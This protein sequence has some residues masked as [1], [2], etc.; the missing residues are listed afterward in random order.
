MADHAVKTHFKNTN[1]V[2]Y[3]FY[4]KSQKLIK[5]VICHLPEATPAEE[6]SDRLM[7]LGYDIIIKHK[8]TTF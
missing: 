3:T 7:D 2:F 4:P 6:V 1:L 8:M 5:A